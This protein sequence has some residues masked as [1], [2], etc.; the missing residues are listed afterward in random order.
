[1]PRRAACRAG[2][3]PRP[4]VSAADPSTLLV[5]AGLWPPATGL[6]FRA[7]PGCPWGLGGGDSGPSLC[8]SWASLG[9]RGQGHYGARGHPPHSSPQSSWGGTMTPPLPP[10]LCSTG[11]YSAILW[12]PGDPRHRL[13]PIHVRGGGRGWGVLG[14]PWPG[15]GPGGVAGGIPVW[16]AAQDRVRGWPSA[17]GGGLP[18]PESQGGMQGDSRH[19][20]PPP[21][22]AGP[23]AG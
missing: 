23:R 16:P 4:Q 21:T 17:H 13:Y 3:V 18:V 8:P 20:S 1:M 12:A 19:C 22:P 5:A 14:Q 9:V 2:T 15:G 7:A 6:T 10:T 11:G